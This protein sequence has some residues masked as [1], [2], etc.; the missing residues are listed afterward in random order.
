MEMRSLME[1]ATHCS[2][3]K[4]GMERKGKSDGET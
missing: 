2:Y 4:D 3:M 1:T